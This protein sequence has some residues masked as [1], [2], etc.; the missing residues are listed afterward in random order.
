MCYTTFAQGEANNWYFGNNAG[1]TFNTNPPSALTDG[2]LDTNEGC[3]SISDINGDLLMYTDGRTIWDKN[4]D[5]MPGADYFG[6]NGLDGLNGDPSSTSSGLIVPHPTELNLYYVFTVDEPHH[7]NANAFPG[8]GPADSSGNNIDIYSDGGFVPQDDDGFNNGLNYTIVNMDLRGGLGDVDPANKNIQLITF[9]NSPNDPKFKASEK[10]TAVRGSDCNSVWLITHFKNKYYSFF[11]NEFGLDPTPVVSEVTPNIPL[12]SYRRGALGYLKASPN[13]DRLLVAHHATSFDRE[14]DIAGQDGSVYVYD[15]NNVTGQ[16]SNPIRL[17][18]N[19]NPYGVEFSPN[20]TRAYATLFDGEHHLYQ[21]DLESSAIPDSQFRVNLESF[22]QST[23]I[24]LGPDGKIYHVTFQSARLGVINSPNAL[25]ADVNYIPGSNLSSVSLSGRSGIFGLPPFIQSLFS[26]RIN[27]INDDQ[28]NIPTE[29]KLCD[30]T[31][32]TLSYISSPGAT[33]TWKKDREI[34]PDENGPE[35]NVV[36]PNNA[37]YPYEV[38]YQLEV[39]FN[40]GECPLIGIARLTFNQSPNFN[41]IELTTCR[42]STSEVP[43]YDLTEVFRILGENNGID[44]EDIEGE[45]YESEADALAENNPIEDFSIFQNDTGIPSIF[46]NI[47]SFETCEEIV[48]IELLVE[49]FPDLFLEDETLILCLENT[50]GL[51]LDASNED[52]ETELEYLW[53]TGETSSQLQVNSGGEYTVDIN[54][55]GFECALTKTFTVIESNIAEF[56]YVV[57]SSGNTNVIEI[58]IANSS[59]GDYDFA[60]DE[61]VNFQDSN[62]FEDLS[63]GIYQVF[64]RDKLGCGLA[65][66]TVGILG[67]MDFFTPN[68]DGINDVWQISGLLDNDQEQI[69]LQVFDRYGKLLSSF[70]NKDRGWD[71]TYNGRN[72]PTDDY[73]YRIQFSNGTLETGNFTLKR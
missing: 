27:I 66:K 61:P 4:H 20:G 24:Q 45:F 54:I 65:E 11:I 58:I 34:L 72:M 19:C 37:E 35:L 32:F 26:E 46:A 18:G 40:D 52:D 33:Y 29:V 10:I 8:Q 59:L 73:W 38:T 30:E 17:V 68:G 21:W 2:Q 55:L 36:V 16:V 31:E 1:I 64:V 44:E 70:T 41:D 53:N 6:T 22:E 69:N 15:F 60:I 28:D 43:E 62:V 57:E 71:G 13:G 49:E 9:G 50:E 12:S 23:A 48:E 47:V 14:D 56:D 67:I 39:N 42:N 25:R 7:E 3:S 63:P 5:I 51:L